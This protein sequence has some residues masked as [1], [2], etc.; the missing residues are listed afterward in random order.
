M[1]AAQ[2][3]CLLAEFKKHV[4]PKSEQGAH[5]ALF[6]ARY[7]GELEKV[8]HPNGATAAWKKVHHA[9][10]IADGGPTM[11]SRK[12]KSRTPR[13]H[14]Q[15]RAKHSRTSSASRRLS[16][17]SF[18]KE[19]NKLARPSNKHEGNVSPGAMRRVVVRALNAYISLPKL[20]VGA[21]LPEIKRATNSVLIEEDTA[22]PPKYEEVTC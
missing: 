18:S 14:K 6:L 17:A 16:R 12:K 11:S 10:A 5:M 13:T 9:A 2:I 8:V 20:N 21:Q 1:Q 22:A 4:G 3:I 7:T 15:S 19:A